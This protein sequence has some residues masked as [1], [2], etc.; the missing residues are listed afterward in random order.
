M[1]RETTTRA[2]DSYGLFGRAWA[3]V[4]SLWLVYWVYGF[5]GGILINYGLGKVAEFLSPYVGLLLFIPLIAYFVWVNVAIWRCAANS[6][7]VWWFLARAS[8]VL[9]IIMIPINIWRG[10]H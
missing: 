8:V 2:Y 1:V 3:G 10:F 6:H 4:E 9:T 5:L 7:P